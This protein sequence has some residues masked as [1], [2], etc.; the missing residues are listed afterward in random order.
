M[1]EVEDAKRD[2]NLLNL[3]SVQIRD[4]F[5]QIC[6]P[7]HSVQLTFARPTIVTI[8]SDKEAGER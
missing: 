2:A 8:G 6:Y 5:I 1:V 7:L 4:A 3:Q